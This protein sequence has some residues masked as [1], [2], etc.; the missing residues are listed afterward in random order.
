M[1]PICSLLS[2]ISRMG[3]VRM[4]SLMRRRLPVSLTVGVKRLL[5]VV[6]PAGQLKEAA[7]ADA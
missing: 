7:T 1:T 3:V 5:M 4:A 6:T 2:S